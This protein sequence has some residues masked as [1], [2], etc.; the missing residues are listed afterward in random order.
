MPGNRRTTRLKEYNYAQ[1]GMY[2]VTIC[3]DNHIQYF[4]CVIDDKMVLNDAGHMINKWWNKLP[5]KYNG[6]EID[7][8]CIMP[9]HLHGIIHIVGAHPCVR[10]ETEQ[11]CRP[12]TEQPWRPVTNKY[13]VFG[14]THRSAPTLG[15]IIQWFKTMSTNEYI[16]NVKHNNWQSFNKRLWQRNYYDHIIRDEIDLNRVREYIINNPA[17]WAEDEYYS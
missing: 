2:S 16:R 3:A 15:G 14:R 13:N 1:K 12:E 4:G 6:I 9:N 10:P 11:P 17:K 7:E 5:D 8:Y